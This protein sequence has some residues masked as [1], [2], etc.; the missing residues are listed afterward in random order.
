MLALP[1]DTPMRPPDAAKLQP[2]TDTVPIR[3]ALRYTVTVPFAN[4]RAP[5]RSPATNVTPLICPSVC[6][7]PGGVNV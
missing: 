1:T 7:F 3:V 6:Q 2:L 4:A 5:K